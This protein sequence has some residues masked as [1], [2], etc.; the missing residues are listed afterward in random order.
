[1]KLFINYRREDTDDLAGRL[2]DRLVVEFGSENLFKDLDSIRPGQKWKRVLEQSVSKSDIVLALIGKQWTS[3]VDQKSGQPRIMN[4]DDWVRYELEAANRNKRLVMSIIVKNAPFPHLDQIPASLHWLLDIHVT[5]V[6]GD[7]YFK[8]DVN[9]L[10]L[11]IKRI[12]D[13]LEE[14]L[15]LEEKARQEEKV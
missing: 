12:R 8:E 9:R 14:R 2:Y 15:R 4:D 11:E 6:R 5:E 7:P 10:I 13:R 3:C 1:M